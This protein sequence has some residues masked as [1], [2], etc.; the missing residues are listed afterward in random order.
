MVVIFALCAA[1]CVQAFA[2]SE[3]VSRQSAEL[4][5]AVIEAQSAAEIWKAHAGEADAGGQLTAAAA[6]LRGTVEQG[7][8][9][10]RY[11]SDWNRLDFSRE[12][13]GYQVSVFP[14][15]SAVTG[16]RRATV[17]V[18]SASQPEALYTLDIA[19]QEVTP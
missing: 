9:A 3:R 18:Y 17:A 5:R 10:V 1:V 12:W 6:D 8:L 19:C 4:D 2:L 13:D 15:P 7:C 11:D 16:L 14:E